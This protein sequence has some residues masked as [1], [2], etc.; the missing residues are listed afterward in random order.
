MRRVLSSYNVFGVSWPHR[1][2]RVSK[3]SCESLVSPKTALCPATRQDKERDSSP[4]RSQRLIIARRHVYSAK[5]RYLRG[6]PAHIRQPT[7]SKPNGLGHYTAIHDEG[8]CWMGYRSYASAGPF[9]LKLN[10]NC[11]EGIPYTGVSGWIKSAR[12]CATRGGACL[13]TS[14]AGQI[15]SVYRPFGGPLN[16]VGHSGIRPYYVYLPNSQIKYWSLHNRIVICTASTP[17]STIGQDAR[18]KLDFRELYID[19]ERQTQHNFTM[20]PLVC[21]SLTES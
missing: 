18:V 21:E 6:P 12:L 13:V 10:K 3:L 17:S 1:Y 20:C 14:R 8:H 5:L 4:L 11:W 7:G 2:S 9:R 19:G 16:R 15:A